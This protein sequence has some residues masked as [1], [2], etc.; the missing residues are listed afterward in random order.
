MFA[1]ELCRS[2]KLA[3]NPQMM[4]EAKKTPGKKRDVGQNKCSKYVGKKKKN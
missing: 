1:E 2:R 4:S 3:I